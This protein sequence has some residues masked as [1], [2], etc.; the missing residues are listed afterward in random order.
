MRWKRRTVDGN[1]DGG[2]GEEIVGGEGGVDVGIVCR[3]W[4]RRYRGGLG[5]TVWERTV[6]GDDV[7]GNGWCCVWRFCGRE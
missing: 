4:Y 7:E 2:G 1:G 3:N 5:T 6:E